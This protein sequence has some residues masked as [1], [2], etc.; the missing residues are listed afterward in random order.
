MS[1]NKIVCLNFILVA[2][3]GAGVMAQTKG[4]EVKAKIIESSE[5]IADKAKDATDA[6]LEKKAEV[7]QSMDE[8]T[9]E[10]KQVIKDKAKDLKE[11]TKDLS[12]EVND[13]IQKVLD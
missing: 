11:D 3:L 1:L 4:D 8:K 12:N 10:A 6:T 9:E 2:F 13:K 7:E 5:V